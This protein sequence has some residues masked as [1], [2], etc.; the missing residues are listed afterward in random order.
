MHSLGEQ[1]VAFAGISLIPRTLRQRHVPELTWAENN[2][3]E[4]RIPLRVMRFGNRHTGK[5]KKK[6][7]PEGKLVGKRIFVDKKAFVTPLGLADVRVCLGR[8]KNELFVRVPL[9]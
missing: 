4:K 8:E 2:G 3:G 9:S 5:R 7:N 1:S 6:K